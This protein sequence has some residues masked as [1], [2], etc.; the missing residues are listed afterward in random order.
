VPSLNAFLERKNIN[1]SLKTYFVDALGAMAMG[2]FASLLIGTIF[3]TLGDKSGIDFFLQV[4]KYAKSVTGAAIGLA[5]AVS[6]KAPA[7]VLLSAAAVGFAGN[8]LGGP[9]GAYV[10]TVIAVEF[11]KMVS[12]ET[13]VD[14]LVTPAVVICSGVFISSL[15]GPAID[16]LM[17]GLGNFIQNATDMRPFMMGIIVSIVVGMCL[18]LPISSAAI[19]IAIGLSGI[20]G[21]AATAG[22]CA[23]MIG[24]AV[25]SFRE[26]RWGGLVAQGLGTSMLQ[27]PNIIKRP[28]IWIPS[29]LTSSIT[30]PISTCVFHLQNIPVGSGMGTCGLVGPIG[31]YSAMPDGGVN[32]WVGLLLVCFV[33]PAVLTLFFSEIM[34]KFG[35]IRSGDL[36]I[37]C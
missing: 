30:G 28:Q 4:A 3:Q 16:A 22:C 10:A 15:L 7:L 13:V 18:T 36:K 35:W 19:C 23:Q 17:N 9:M 33:L 27:M 8:F 12:K 34:R 6:L 31:I 32:M 14:I 20:A 1:V 25:M 5:I 24:F 37:D 2:L 21:G 26:N 11:G 29:I